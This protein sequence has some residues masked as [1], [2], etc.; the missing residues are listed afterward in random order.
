M[1]IFVRGFFLIVTKFRGGHNVCTYFT[2]VMKIS[3]ENNKYL[4]F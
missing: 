4:N 1:R 3:P 2:E